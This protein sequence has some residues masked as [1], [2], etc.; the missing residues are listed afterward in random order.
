MSNRRLRRPQSVASQ[1]SLPSCVTE[2]GHGF[3]MLPP[4]HLQTIIPPLGGGT[5]YRPC[6]APML[7]FIIAYYS[8]YYKKS[9]M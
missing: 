1:P 4:S 2:G 3:D 6:G 7:Y 5:Y 8:M 9:P